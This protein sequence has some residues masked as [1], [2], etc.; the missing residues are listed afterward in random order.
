MFLPQRELAIVPQAKITEYLLSDTHA[1]GRHKAQFFRK[2]GYSLDDWQ[3]LE[4]T[5]SEHPLHNE[6][7][8]IEDYPFG[9]RF[10]IEGIIT[11]PDSRQP[12][13]RTVWFIKH[14]EEIPHFVTAYPLGRSEQ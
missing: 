3:A 7:A 10:V 12:Y 11:T 1:D 8:K 14:G 6:V 2:F 13:L 5:L 4:R 9:A